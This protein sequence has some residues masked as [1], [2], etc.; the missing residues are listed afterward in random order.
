MEMMT[1]DDINPPHL[2]TQPLKLIHNL[3]P[4][5]LLALLS[6]PATTIIG[7]TSL[8]WIVVERER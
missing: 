4:L 5:V 1:K 2:F 6:V 3:D 7:V 8:L